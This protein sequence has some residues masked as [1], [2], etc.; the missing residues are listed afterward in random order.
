[1]STLM[2]ASAA[3]CAG[4]VTQRFC[5][6]GVVGVWN[7]YFRELNVG[8]VFFSEIAAATFV[9]A[10]VSKSRGIGWAVFWSLFYF[11]QV[12]LNLDLFARAHH[13]VPESPATWA[14][15]LTSGQVERID[16]LIALAGI[17]FV[18][19]TA[20]SISRDWFLSSFK[21]SQNWKGG[22]GAI[23]IVSSIILDESVRNVMGRTDYFVQTGVEISLP[24]IGTIGL[25]LLL[26]S[27]RPRT[28]WTLGLFRCSLIGS[29]FLAGLWVAI[30]YERLKGA[31]SFL[32]GMLGWCVLLP[33]LATTVL[34]TRQS[35]AIPSR[36]SS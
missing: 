35:L 12:F 9:S 22:V 31:N 1:M 20:E 3:L 2:R 25:A 19:Y 34:L 24:F 32:A 17:C 27:I 29:W 28:L 16:V 13:L 10:T 21:L 18:G 33:L 36:T 11:I 15:R 6:L 26:T 8:V 7:Y 4:V 14:L 5:S 30:F 23:L